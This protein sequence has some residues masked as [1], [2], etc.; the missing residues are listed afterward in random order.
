MM[1]DPNDDMLD[2]LFAEARAVTPTPSQ[3]LVARVLADADVARQA[4][5]VP[6]VAQPGLIARIF[7]M[8]GGW[9]AVSGLAAATIAGVWVGVAPPASVED[10]AASTFGDS[11]AIGIFADD[12]DFDIGTFTDG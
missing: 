2:D 4:E 6:V 12:L 7:D 10:F 9:P 5:P 8:I 11:V 1:T 3:A